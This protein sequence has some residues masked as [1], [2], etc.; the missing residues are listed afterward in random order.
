MAG[1]VDPEI[2]LARTEQIFGSVQTGQGHLKATVLK[3]Q[4]GPVKEVVE[5]KEV[6]QSLLV[7]GYRLTNGVT[8]QHQ[9]FPALLFWNGIWTVSSLQ[10]ILERR[11]GKALPILPFPS[12]CDQ[13]HRSDHGGIDGAK[14]EK[15]G[16]HD[17]A[18]GGYQS[19]AYLRTGAGR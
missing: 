17:Q 14:Y 19:W 1:A 7:M 13:R 10:T 5:E 4:A 6:N 16:D 3:E 12:R 11:S 15:L 9:Q 8:Y 18:G 2:V